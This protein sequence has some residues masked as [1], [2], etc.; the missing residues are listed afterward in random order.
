M[1]Q[2][3]NKNTQINPRKITS[4]CT[5][6]GKGATQGQGNGNFSTS[7][8]LTSWFMYLPTHSEGKHGSLQGLFRKCYC[9]VWQSVVSLTRNTYKESQKLEWKVFPKPSLKACKPTLQGV[10]WEIYHIHFIKAKMKE[11]SIKNKKQ[12]QTYKVWIIAVV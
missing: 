10:W 2:F 11:T 1:F 9:K 7:C 5:S 6:S 12:P 8:R 4:R 3:K